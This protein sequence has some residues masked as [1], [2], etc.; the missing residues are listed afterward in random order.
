LNRH[1]QNM[2]MAWRR[3]LDKDNSMRVGY[4]EFVIQCKTLAKKGL[5]EAHPATGINA[6]Y[7]ALDED[8]SGWFTLR[9]WDA[10]SFDVLAKFWRWCRKEFGTVAKFAKVAETVEVDIDEPDRGGVSYEKFAKAVRPL[11]YTYAERVQLF[12]AL[13]ATTKRSEGKS[14]RLFQ[15]DV[16]FLDKWDPDREVKE[17]KLWSAMVNSR[18]NKAYSLKPSTSMRSDGG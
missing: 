9:D 2:L 17:D 13:Q 8:R 12:E 14:G 4:E 11:E 7:I 10:D 5:A 3:A 1:N 6:L 18:A 16:G 15:G